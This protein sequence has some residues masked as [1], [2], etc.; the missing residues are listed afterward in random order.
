M[1][2]WK[3]TTL[4]SQDKRLTKMYADIPCKR[5]VLMALNA[6]AE[7]DDQTLG[8]LYKTAPRVTYNC[9]D[10][11]FSDTLDAASEVSLRF[12]RWFYRLQFQLHK[13]L[14]IKLR[15]DQACD[16]E[17]TGARSSRSETIESAK[18]QADEEINQIYAVV[19]GA[20][21]FA[22]RLGISIDRALAFST[23]VSLDRAE[24]DPYLL[25]PDHVVEHLRDQINEV[26]D[27]FE[28]LWRTCGRPIPRFT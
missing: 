7:D 2:L 6:L 15:Q 11:E 1:T 22:E 9:V 4:R 13:L 5:R 17:V 26:A 24:M 16:G 25:A 18:R 28:S 21:R 14:C 10:A 3:G 20:E 8:E 23:V 12:D 19:L 27:A